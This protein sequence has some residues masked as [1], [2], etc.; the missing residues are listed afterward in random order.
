M[1]PVMLELGMMGLYSDRSW[2]L[3]EPQ[4][5]VISKLSEVVYQSN[6]IFTLG[7]LFLSQFVLFK[8]IRSIMADSRKTV[9]ITG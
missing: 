8:K 3:S 9:L 6:I 4:I 2:K 7:R 1:A 5:L